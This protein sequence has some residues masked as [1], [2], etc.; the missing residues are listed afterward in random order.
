MY[1]LPAECF[2][3]H[4]T[5]PVPYI[6]SLKVCLL[7]EYVYLPIISLIANLFPSEYFP[8]RIFVIFSILPLFIV[9]SLSLPRVVSSGQYSIFLVEIF[10][11]RISSS[12]QVF[13][14]SPDNFLP[15]ERFYSFQV[16]LLQIICFF[17]RIC[18]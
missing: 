5:F 18:P 13:F 8:I 9:Q 14:F 1:F 6:Y 12:Y 3:L 11:F 17:S 15:G 4:L 7:S 16:S 10:Q 2:S